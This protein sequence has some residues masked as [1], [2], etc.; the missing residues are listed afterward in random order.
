MKALFDSLTLVMVFASPAFVLPLILGPIILYYY[1]DGTGKLAGWFTLKP[2]LAT[3]LWVITAV[4]LGD[5]NLPLGLIAALSL[6]PAVLLTL[7][8]VWRFRRS[9]QVDSRIPFAFV[10]ADALRWL[11][12]FTLIH[13]GSTTLNDPFFLLGWILPNA[14]AIMALVLLRLRKK[15]LDAL[16]ISSQ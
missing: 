13:F 16:A 14:Y 11:N 4:L 6:A 8:I 9:F 3:P 12:T 7:L 5:L 2:L 10:A 1:K 15:Q